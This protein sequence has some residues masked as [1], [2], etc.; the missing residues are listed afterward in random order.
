MNTTPALIISLLLS[1]AL[2]FGPGLSSA[3]ARTQ[4]P[5]PHDTGFESKTQRSHSNLD[6]QTFFNVV[7]ANIL[8]L[9][10][11]EAQSQ[12]LLNRAA[13]HSGDT[14][15]LRQA[16]M[17]A[18]QQR[19]YPLAE[20]ALLRWF[21]VS[22]YDADAVSLA[23]ATVRSPRSALY[24][25]IQRYLKVH[26]NSNLQIDWAQKLAALGRK[27]EA[28]TLILHSIKQNPSQAR[29]W[30]MLGALQNERQGTHKA[31]NSFTKYMQ[32]VAQDK[33]LSPENARELRNV[34]H[35]ALADTYLQQ[36]RIPLMLQHLD[37]V[38]LEDSSVTS[39]LR[40]L[41]LYGRSQQLI[42]AEKVLASF[43]GDSHDARELR[44]QAQLLLYKEAQAWQAAWDTLERYNRATLATQPEWLYEQALLS[45]Q[46]K[47]WEVMERQLNYVMLN[48][49][50][51]AHAWN[52]LGYSL[53]D[54]GLRLDEARTLLTRA[55]ELEPNS[56]RILDSM[57][58]LAF[59]SGHTAEAE[60]Y[61]S[62]AWSIEPDAEVAAHLG[63]V[64]WARGK[65]DAA[66]ATWQQ[67]LRLSNSDQT[68]LRQTLLRLN[69]QPK[70]LFAAPFQ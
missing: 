61:L 36:N 40:M 12:V 35:L 26:T 63:E 28:E 52:A 13:L 7:L 46:L 48:F 67:G 8:N 70:T 21:K 6:A 27:N 43:S 45:A 18:L 11:E 4:N 53:A 47:K 39:R 17:Q 24:K 29:A 1:Q 38:T 51:F 25:P 14:E 58:W 56:P 54:R 42:P 3:Y 33:S 49:P 16:T 50:T 5:T 60:E 19:Q 15:L 20:S 34:G 65:Q 2:G 30:F 9:R 57:G 44:M 64:Q 23:I 37:S 69:V 62:R 66:R 10:G 55:L 68:V 31:L 22:P 59:R 32:Y 41:A